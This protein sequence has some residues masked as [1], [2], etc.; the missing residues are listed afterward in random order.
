MIELGGRWCRRLGLPQSTGRI[1][2]LLYLSAAPM[3]LDDIVLRLRISKASASLGTRQLVTLGALRQVWVPGSRRDHFA[4][5]ED[6][7]ALLRSGYR[8]FLKPRLR[9]ARAQLEA[10]TGSLNEDL[11]SGRIS[12]EECK[13]LAS[14]LRHLSR[15]QKKV[16]AA[17]PLLERFL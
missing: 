3:S 11:A 9:S 16:E 4:V 7:L 15:V 14:R 1:Y 12:R 10:L 6:L 8:E 13:V 5:V 17:A 2:G